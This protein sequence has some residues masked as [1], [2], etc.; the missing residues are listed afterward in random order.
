MNAA[1]W[2]DHCHW[3]YIVIRVTAGLAIGYA[4][5]SYVGAKL[6]WKKALEA[7]H[8]IRGDINAVIDKRVEEQA[9]QDRELAE[10]LELL[11]LLEQLKSHKNG[12]NE[13]A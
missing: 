5:G 10:L 2:Q 7:V 13:N 3:I 9:R 1:N 6:A 4:I 8:G 11:E 12:E